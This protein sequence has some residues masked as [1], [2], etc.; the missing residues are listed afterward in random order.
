[1]YRNQLRRLSALFPGGRRILVFSALALT[2][3]S[4]APVLN[5]H[6]YVPDDEALARIEPAQ[7]TRKQ[8]EATLGSPSTVSTFGDKVW[9]YMNEKTET[10]A[11]FEPEVVER[12]IVAVIFGENDIVD[13]VVTYTEADGQ[14]IRIVSR[15]TPTAGNEVTLLQQLFGNIGRFSKGSE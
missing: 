9:Y 15:T 1:M 12:H 2:L 8:V 13:D 4:C 14:E 7:T 6:G 11:F 3:T 5:V 10:V